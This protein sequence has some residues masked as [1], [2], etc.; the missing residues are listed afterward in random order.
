MTT[1]PPF[2]VRAQVAEQRRPA[3]PHV[4]F[5]FFALGTSIALFLAML[6]FLELGRQLGL[7]Q[8]AK[9]G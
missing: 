7:S 9:L 2:A 8:A 6:L 5:A 1:H 3:S 4:R